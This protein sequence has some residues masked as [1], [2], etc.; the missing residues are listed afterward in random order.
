MPSCLPSFCDLY[1]CQCRPFTGECSICKTHSVVCFQECFPASALVR[2]EGKGSVAMRSLSAG[3][4]VLSIDRRGNT[5]YDT[6]CFF[7]HHDSNS[8][9][10]FCSISIQGNAQLVHQLLLTPTHFLPVGPALPQLSYKYA[11]D[12][13][14]GDT[15]WMVTDADPQH[16]SAISAKVL[17]KNTLQAQGLYNPYTEVRLVS[18]TASVFLSTLLCL[19]HVE[20]CML[21]REELHSD[22]FDVCKSFDPVVSLQ[23]SFLYLKL[24]LQCAALQCTAAGLS[25][26]TYVVY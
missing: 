16:A 4:K 23:H 22:E 18:N 1:Y 6:V 21:S 11:K 7:G 10:S 12:V 5:I 2:V 15:V 13:S 24:F 25:T 17:G 14:I 26:P 20:K 9:G 19:R 8:W 3:D